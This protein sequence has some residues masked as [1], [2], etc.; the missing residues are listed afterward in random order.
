MFNVQLAETRAAGAINE[1]VVGHAGSAAWVIDGASGV[2]D[3]LVSAESDAQWFAQRVDAELRRLLALEPALPFDELFVT[4]VDRCRS[5]HASQARRPAKGR[6]ELPS[7]AMAFA[8]VLPGAVELAT[9][10]DCEI[11]YRASPHD[12]LLKHGNGGN[13][14]PFEEHTKAMARAIVADR[15]GISDSELFEA[16]K[17]QLVQ[18]RA[19]MNIDGGYWVLGLQPEA[20]GHADRIELPLGE[21]TILL[22]SDGILRLS[23]MFDRIEREALLSIESR[24]DFEACY[25]DLRALERAPGSIARHP[26]PKVSDDASLVR[27][28]VHT[29]AVPNG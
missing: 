8:R 15:P 29:N 21:W 20:I 25:S 16:L 6:H 23:D 4:I 19:A 27:I 24:D 22:A 18:N 7:A 5:A 26:R 3:N 12:A 1:D 28:E 2:G 11:L 14:G 13:I 17:P 9:F 10:G